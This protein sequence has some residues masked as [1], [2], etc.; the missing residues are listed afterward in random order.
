MKRVLDYDP[1]TGVTTWH[2]YDHLTRQTTIAE[3]QDVSA[4]IEYSRN[5]A[6]D[7]DASRKGRKAEWWHV[8]TI[9]IGVQ[10]K[11]LREHGVNIYDPSHSQRV[12]KLLND[13]DWRYLR[14]ANGK[15]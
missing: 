3:T 4:A 9:P 14:T 7:E 15:I 10:Y 12:T 8:A 11:W 13:S 2:E 6:N 5:K 1:I